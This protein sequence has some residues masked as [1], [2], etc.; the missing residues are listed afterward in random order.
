MGRDRLSRVS[1]VIWLF[2]RCGAGKT[3]L[4]RMLGDA[5]RRRQRPVLLLDGD[6]VRMGLSRD[7]GFS[8]EDREENHRRI[9]EV[10]V[11]A[12]G[13]GIVTV[14]AT[15][16]PEFRQR[17]LVRRVVGDRLHWVYVDT[18]IEECVRR[19][20]KGLY[21]RAALG[22][23]D[24]LVDYPFEDPRPGEA[25]VSVSTGGQVPEACLERLWAGLEGRLGPGGKGQGH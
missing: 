23:V 14:V 15:M 22:E 21:R 6:P 24:G 2:G 8:A 5:L 25:A 12:A 16:A 11:L 10:A 1:D 17:D 18:P 19:D 3:T 4:A 13:Q 7:L 20:P 9:A